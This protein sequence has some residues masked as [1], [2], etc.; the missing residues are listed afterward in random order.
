MQKLDFWRKPESR[1]CLTVARPTNNARYERRLKKLCERKKIGQA[2]FSRQGP[3]QF[4]FAI[5]SLLTGERPTRKVKLQ[6]HIRN[7]G[8]QAQPPCTVG[9]CLFVCL[10]VVLCQAQA[11]H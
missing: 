7:H 11:M 2:T 10:F 1:V 6:R 3:A 9:R 8:N 4:P 5:D